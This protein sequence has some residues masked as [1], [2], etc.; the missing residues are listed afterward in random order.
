MILIWSGILLMWIQYD[1]YLPGINPN[2]VPGRIDADFHT[3]PMSLKEDRALTAVKTA[4]EIN[5]V[6]ERRCEMVR[7]VKLS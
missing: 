6:N 3:R 1:F 5:Q 2:A 7:M 4:G